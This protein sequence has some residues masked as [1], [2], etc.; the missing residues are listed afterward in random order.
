MASNSHGGECGGVGVFA[1]GVFVLEEKR[2]PLKRII[3]G[4]SK[5]CFSL[6]PSGGGVCSER[7]DIP[8]KSVSQI[9]LMLED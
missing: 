4:K 5:E 9:L 8:S 3:G 7:N 1:L 6:E 2:G